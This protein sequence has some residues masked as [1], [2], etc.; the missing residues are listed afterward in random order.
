MMFGLFS[1]QLPPP[2]IR[3][4]DAADAD[5]C[6]AVHRTGFDRPWDRHEFE[7]LLAGS[8]V[9]AHVALSRQLVVGF[10][11]CRLVAD[12]AEILS[13][14]VDPGRRRAGVGHLLLARQLSELPYSGVRRLFL[15]VDEGNAAALSLYRRHGFREVGRRQS[16]YRKADG[17]HATALVMRRDLS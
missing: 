5:A 13:I 15:E 17:S 2:E 7:R 1:R 4:A 9:L 14:A 6:A 3:P 8:G 12:E 11:L 16:Y 10:C